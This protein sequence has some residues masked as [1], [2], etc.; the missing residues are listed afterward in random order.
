LRLPV[1]R[2]ATAV[3]VSM[4]PW[5]I[6]DW[7]RDDRLARM[8]SRLVTL[9]WSIDIGGAEHLP[10]SG[11]G[12]VVVNARQ[13]ML[14]PWFTALALSRELRRPVRFVGRPDTAPIGALARRL[15]GLL[16]RPD[17]VAGAL[18]DGQLLVFGADGVFDP[19]DVG[20]VDHTVV[21][22]AVL[23]AS[24][25]FPAAVSMSPIGRS[26]RLDVG[27]VVRPPRR[28]RGPCAELE[29]ADRL[30]DVLREQLDSG[31]PPRTGTP[32]DWIPLSLSG[33]Q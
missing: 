13:F 3:N 25:V 8:A 9:R 31:G 23:T 32:L 7:G 28:R 24:P 6:D 19:R 29:L 18:R 21:G 27:D 17:E 16:A 15:G 26:A 2:I 33:G 14:T 20:E 5:D 4:T 10:S 11:A 30:R 22:A 1:G 12:L